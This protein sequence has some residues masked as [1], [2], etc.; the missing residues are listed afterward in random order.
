[1]SLEGF[2]VWILGGKQNF[3]FGD[4][5]EVAALGSDVIAHKE[6]EKDEEEF[7]PAAKE[8]DD[9]DEEEEDKKPAAST[10]VPVSFDCSLYN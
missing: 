5:D 4:T 1:M 9:D 2:S 7:T 8:D 10:S 3:D 6:S